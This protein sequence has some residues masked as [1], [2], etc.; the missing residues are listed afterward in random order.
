MIT[1]NYDEENLLFGNHLFQYSLIRLIALKNNYNFHVKYPNHLLHCFPNL[2]LGICDG[3]TYKYIEEDTQTQ[4]YIESVFN[5]PDFIELKGYYQTPKYFEGNE[6]LVKSWFNIEIDNDV[7]S[8]INRFPVDKYC[9]IHIRGADYK[10]NNWSLPTK[11]YLDAMEEV[12]KINKD[13]SFVIVTDD[14]ELSETLFPDI[15]IITSEAHKYGTFGKNGVVDFKSLYFSKY[16]IISASTF[17]WWAAWL[18]TD[19]K[20]IIIAPNNWL[21]HN[22]PE[23][24]FYP[25]DIKTKEFTYL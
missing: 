8:I 10:S 21:N 9:Y 20:E 23:R 15:E 22:F 19:H 2:D 6:D 18:S 16:C 13:I 4:T 3:E 24:G 1:I 17:S 11:Y 14:I 7:L 25:V 12:K 5:I